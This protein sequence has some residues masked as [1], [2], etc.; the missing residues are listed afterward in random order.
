MTSGSRGLHIWVP[1][2]KS[3][4]TEE[5][6]AFCEAVART[7]ADRHPDI[8]T[9]EFTKA[10]RGDRIYVDVGRNAPAQHAVAPYSLRA[11][12]G[13]PIAT[14]IPW[15]ELDD[16]DLKPQRYTIHAQREGDDPWTGLR[17]AARAL[18]PAAKK[19]Q[20]LAAT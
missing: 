7:L 8:L 18:G 12:D 2:R 20:R 4:T 3:G 11:K 16:A 15:D 14:P 17:K 1:L 10:E 19:L 13:A 5:V 6:H 9:T